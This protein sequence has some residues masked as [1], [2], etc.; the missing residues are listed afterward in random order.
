MRR[1]DEDM[2]MFRYIIGSKEITGDSVVYNISVEFGEGNI[3]SYSA[4]PGIEVTYNDFEI[5]KPLS[6]SFNLSVDS[7]EINYCLEGYLESE[8]ANRK[9]VYMGDGDISIF[10]Y[11]TGV[12]LADFTTKHYKGVTVMVYIDKA[13]KSIGDMLGVSDA[14]IKSFIMASFNGDTCIVNHASQSLEHIFKEFFVLP[15]KF[16]NY[17][18]RIK[19]VEL[20]LYILGNSDYK[21]SN[22][23]YFPRTFVD[24][25]KDA[26]RIILSDI[27]SHITI[28]E[29]SHRVGINSTDLQKGFKAIYQCPIYAYLK[30]YRMKKAKELLMKE[31]LTIAHIANLVGYTNN[32]KFSKAFKEEF[33]LSPSKYRISSR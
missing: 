29:L 12:V 24:K 15:E 16:K 2:N 13:S 21:T 27:D 17:F 5:Y 32:S 9:I 11:K 18:L 1:F 33:G 3:I 26:R 19:V 20:L 22:K 6:E 7:L 14:E 23:K 25:I 28:K 4:M 30:S 8:F 31:E 10:G